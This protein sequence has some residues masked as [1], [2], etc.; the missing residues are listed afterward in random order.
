VRHLGVERYGLLALV[1]VVHDYFGYFDFGLGR[2]AT[3][4]LAEVIHDPKRSASARSVFLTVIVFHIALGL[5]VGLLF[6]LAAP[7]AAEWLLKGSTSIVHEGKGTLAAAALFAPVL[8]FLVAVRGTLEALQRFDLVN[9]VKVPSNALTYMIPLVGA[10]GG[11]SLPQIVI[12]LVG[13][14]CITGALYFT[15]SLRDLPGGAVF[16]VDWGLARPLLSFGGGIMAANVAGLFLVDG[17]R[18]LITALASVQAL[19]YYSI[20]QDVV[21]RLWI[22]PASLASAL[23]PMFAVAHNRDKGKVSALYADS[24]LYLLL[25]FVPVIVVLHA[26]GRELLGLWMGHSFATEATFVL[27]VIT[28]GVALDAVARIPLTFLQASGNPGIPARIRWL[29]VPLFLG[30]SAWAIARW[31]IAGA[32]VVWTGRVAVETGVLFLVTERGGFL[33]LPSDTRRRLRHCG[34][35]SLI[36]VVAAGMGKWLI[37]PGFVV[38]LVLVVALLLAFAWYAWTMVVD[39]GHRHRINMLVS[40]VLAL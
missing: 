2:A 38:E 26:F 32:A 5:G 10:L 11:L 24:T 28:V 20:P 17:N 35:V 6:F 8:L 7:V 22:V 16:G 29:L 33:V 34:L 27:Q 39:P 31:G 25:L 18:L 30:T 3:R 19:T 40:K 15:L 36:V 12:L 13:M 9:A 37:A 4:L 21:S 1:L 14:R 23:F